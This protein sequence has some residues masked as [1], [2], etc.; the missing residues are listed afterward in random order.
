MTSKQI[1]KIRR[2]GLLAI[3]ASLAAVPFVSGAHAQSVAPATSTRTPSSRVLAT[4]R[5]KLGSLEGL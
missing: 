4:G 2:R 1:V 5:R 3:A